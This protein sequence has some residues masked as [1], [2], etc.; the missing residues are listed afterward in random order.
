MSELRSMT[1]QS[2]HYFMAYALSMVA[3]FISFPIYTRLFSVSDYG[4]LNVI[5]STVFF[6]MAAAKLGIQNSIIR[7]Y[8]EVK[9]NAADISLRS[10][11]STLTFGPLAVV[12]IACLLYGVSIIA[13]RGH[14]GGSAVTLYFLL[15]AVWVFFL[16]SNTILKNF[17]RAEQ[18]T[19]LFT[20]L[21]IVSKFLSLVVGVGLVYYVF[22]SLLGLF[23][24]FIITES[25]TFAFLMWRLYVKERIFIG[26]FSLAF[27]K[28]ALSYGLPLVVS[29]M[30]SIILNS[31]GRYVILF[32]MSAAA[33]GMYSAGYDLAMSVMESL[34]FPLSFAITPIYMKIY[35]QKGKQET[36]VFLSHCLRYFLLIALPCIFG[37][38][39]LGREI[40]IFIAS[41]KYEQAY[42]IIPYVSWGVLIF[43]LSSIFNAGLFIEKKNGVI[44]F[45][46]VIAGTVNIALNFILIPRMGLVGS[47][48]A[49]LIVY[50][51]LFAVLA[52]RSFEF[53][54]FR[55][56]FANI[57]RYLMSSVIMTVMISFIRFD[58][59]L[60]SLAVKFGA[61]IVAYAAL[62]L[63]F[64]ADIRSRLSVKFSGKELAHEAV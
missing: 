25:L 12:G 60:V 17:L 61:G 19:A 2:S 30:T 57:G 15:S 24:S 27:F 3:S 33:V 52:F 9:S 11:Y 7:F 20:G 32:Y 45:W 62:V 55:I 18:N 14:L 16:C 49:T 36:G 63:M 35:S 37:L 21:S 42:A 31:G 34:I 38:N 40:T 47:A 4:I 26:G 51:S 6:V 8:E 28:K 10:F 22:K 29:E 48:I 50:V 13:M 56:D 53:L 46:T 39:L 54:P 23:V 64:D 43:G 59:P 41:H 1:K 58:K 5:S 44:T